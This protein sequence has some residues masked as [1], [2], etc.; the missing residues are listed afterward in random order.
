[1]SKIYFIFMVAL[2]SSCCNNYDLFDKEIKTKISTIDMNEIESL[3]DLLD[4]LNINS[5]FSFCAV[6]GG[7]EIFQLE[8]G[9]VINLIPREPQTI[10][11]YNIDNLLT[12]N[13]SMVDKKSGEARHY[14]KYRKVYRGVNIYRNGI[15]VAGKHVALSK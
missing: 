3:D 13:K 12:D 9:L 8:N 15:L 5:E 2:L 1:M 11:P 4:K 10:I 14:K 7:C 6:R